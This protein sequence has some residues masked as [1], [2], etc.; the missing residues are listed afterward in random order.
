M[1]DNIL[2]LV[3][4]EEKPRKNDEGCKIR[5][6][7][8]IRPWLSRVNSR[9]LIP[10]S[11][12][13]IQNFKPA[14]S[15]SPKV[16]EGDATLVNPFHNTRDIAHIAKVLYNNFPKYVP[17][18][19][20]LDKLEIIKEEINLLEKYVN[21]NDFCD[22]SRKIPVPV[23]NNFGWKFQTKPENEFHLL[24]NNFFQTLMSSVNYKTWTLPLTAFYRLYH[25]PHARESME[26]SQI[27][28]TYVLPDN[29]VVERFYNNSSHP[30]R[31]QYVYGVKGV[32]KAPIEMTTKYF[33]TFGNFLPTSRKSS[34]HMRTP[35]V[36]TISDLLNPTT[37]K[38]RSRREQG[39]T[40]FTKFTKPSTNLT[41]LI[42]TNLARAYKPHSFL[43]FESNFFPTEAILNRHKRALT[44]KS[45]TPKK[46]SNPKKI[47]H[48][49]TKGDEIDE[50][51]EIF[52]LEAEPF[53][54][55]VR[56]KR[57]V[58]SLFEVQKNLPN[59]PHYLNTLNRYKRE[60]NETLISTKK[61][62][63]RFFD[64][65]NLYHQR[66]LKRIPEKIPLVNHVL[67][68]TI[69]PLPIFN[70]LTFTRPSLIIPDQIYTRIHA[71]PKRDTHDTYF[72]ISWITPDDS[73]VITP[74]TTTPLPTTTTIK[75][76]KLPTTTR[77]FQT[78]IIPSHH[79][80]LFV[81]KSV[82]KT[83]Q[84]KKH[85]PKRSFYLQPELDVTTHPSEI[86]ETLKKFRNLLKLL[87]LK[88]NASSQ[89][90]TIT[91]GMIEYQTERIELTPIP[92]LALPAHSFVEKL[93]ARKTTLDPNDS[94]LTTININE[95]FRE[96]G[97]SM[98]GR[99]F[100][101]PNYNQTKVTPIPYNLE[102]YQRWDNRMVPV[103]RAYKH[104]VKY[105]RNGK[106][107]SLLIS[108]ESDDFRFYQRENK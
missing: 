95:R 39:F 35:T 26:E 17:K 55:P 27:H 105:D 42:Q 36:L 30:K 44:K 86:A 69:S 50:I 107:P 57:I 100:Q 88:K 1:V 12:N 78:R 66:R 18:L 5:S 22:E 23:T 43:K 15:I 84:T 34:D 46:Y 38:L 29:Q 14:Y 25:M 79:R 28:Y 97:Q 93:R 71:R 51:D 4:T 89:G 103:D 8:S 70:N 68:T 76:T 101:N 47:K 92:G 81:H 41:N 64:L 62:T 45:R 72:P 21:E 37:V 67:G 10:A 108:A 98:Q 48:K 49:K 54:R 31:E 106:T 65:L 56:S 11:M 87:V 90:S 63:R 7:L 94:E 80:F 104:N 102:N 33:V 82:P 77:G 3:H 60:V 74:E 32:S 52:P 61:D 40:K 75:P 59:T 53:L 73:Y 83:N 58:P 91:S 6:K 99:Y 20:S 19:A 2:K 9:R 85:R 96:F 24:N 16:A 13:F